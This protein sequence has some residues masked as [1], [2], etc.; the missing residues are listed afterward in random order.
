MG[1][2]RHGECPAA[3]SDGQLTLW[4]LCLMRE[5]NLPWNLPESDPGRRR[6]CC[7]RRSRVPAGP[8]VARA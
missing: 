5:F 7:R 4:Q 3:A 1:L 2:R 6:Q 8:P